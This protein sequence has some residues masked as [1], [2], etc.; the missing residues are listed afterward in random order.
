MSCLLGAVAL[1]LPS[2]LWWGIVSAKHGVSAILDGRFGVRHNDD[3]SVVRFPQ[4]D[5]G[6]FQAAAEIKCRE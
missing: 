4:Q 2:P 3:K 1:R 5:E 6:N